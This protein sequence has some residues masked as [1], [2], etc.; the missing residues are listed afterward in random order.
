MV[1]WRHG[2]FTGLGSDWGRTPRD[3]LDWASYYHD[4]AYQKMGKK[5][6]FLPSYA[7]KAWIHRAKRTRPKTLKGKVHKYG[8]LAWFGAKQHLPLPSGDAKRSQMPP[9]Q[10]PL[11]KPVMGSKRT[12]A[13]YGKAD[14]R[15]S[16]GRASKRYKKGVTPHIK[17]RRKKRRQAKQKSLTKRVRQIVARNY[18][19]GPWTE[20]RVISGTLVSAI[21][22]VGWRQ[23]IG[24]GRLD[25]ITTHILGDSGPQYAGMDNN[26]LVTR[27]EQPDLINQ[28]GASG[29]G[30]QAG[31]KYKIG[32]KSQWVLRNNSNFPVELCFYILKC[33]TYTDLTAIEEIDECYVSQIKD[34]VTGDYAEDPFQYFSVTGVSASKRQWSIHSKQ[35]VTL[36]GGTEHRMTTVIPEFLYDVDFNITKGTATDEY[37]KNSYVLLIRQM[38]VCAH[39]FTDPTTKTGLANSTVDYYRRDFFTTR[40]KR[41]LAVR[42]ETKDNRAGFD[43]VAAV[44]ADEELVGVGVLDVV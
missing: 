23:E 16:N 8:G 11:N 13:S 33:N 39:D 19:E 36:V 5:A 28:S 7:D 34:S 2:H 17:S 27:V 44:V 24:L 14:K 12:Y 22:T 41:G 38:G 21:N 37:L 1:W 9:F 43:I 30:A 6:Y 3:R 25:Q 15:V 20:R 29:I 18:F 10:G 26:N 40:V 32:W 31:A 35:S 42:Q 4:K